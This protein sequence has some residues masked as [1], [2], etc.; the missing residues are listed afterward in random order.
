M[1]TGRSVRSLM[2][3][4]PRPMAT[5]PDWTSSR[6]PNGSTHL[7]EAGQLLG[8]AGD[9][10]GHGVGGDVDDA[11]LEQLDGVEDLAAGDGVGLAP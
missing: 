5:T 4:E 9:L 3:R 11:G 10:D 2:D 8:V 7:Q 1:G 6:M